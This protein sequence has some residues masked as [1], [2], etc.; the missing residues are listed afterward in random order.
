MHKEI[1]SREQVEIVKKT[2]E[3]FANEFNVN[4]FI[5]QLSYFDDLN[6]K[7]RIVYKKGFEVSDEEVKKS[8]I[9]FSLE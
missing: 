1:L 4:M 9:D 5:S 6:Y 3:I 8:L 7:E 2:K